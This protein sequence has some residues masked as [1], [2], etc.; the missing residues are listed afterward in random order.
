[1]GVQRSADF[2]TGARTVRRQKR[3]IFWHVGLSNILDSIGTKEL[4]GREP[5]KGSHREIVAAILVGSEL[6]TKIHEREEGMSVVETLL[7]LAVAALHLAVMPWR[8]RSNQFVMNAVACKRRFEQG[9]DIA[10]AV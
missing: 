4:T 2:V 5:V 9:R 10:L 6:P 8:V 7:I 3:L 1:M